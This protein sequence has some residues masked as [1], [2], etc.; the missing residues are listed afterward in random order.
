VWFL[1]TE[2][3]YPLQARLGLQAAAMLKFAANCCV[4]AGTLL[5]M[6]A[7]VMAPPDDPARRV[8]LLM[9]PSDCSTAET[10]VKYLQIRQ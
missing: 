10:P 8:L 2:S 1:T 9:M 4:A 7:A 5:Q 6:A 3:R